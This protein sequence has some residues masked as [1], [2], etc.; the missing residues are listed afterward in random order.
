M[1]L[2]L[3]FI[4]VIAA[5]CLRS[6]EQRPSRRQFLKNW[7]IGSGVWL[8]T[9]FLIPVIALSSASRATSGCR[10]GINQAVPP[11]YVSS[12]NVHWVATYTCMNGG[13]KTK[14]VPASQVPGGG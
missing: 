9:G 4:A 14:S 11:E 12:D 13:T 7:A 1:T 8:C 3:P 10:G 6:V 5:L 2:F